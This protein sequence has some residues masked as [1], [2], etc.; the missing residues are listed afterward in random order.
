MSNFYSVLEHIQVF[1]YSYEKSTNKTQCLAVHY[2]DRMSV[3]KQV[4]RM[5][6]L[7]ETLT[8]ELVE[9]LSNLHFLFIKK[10]KLDFLTSLK[11]IIKI[12]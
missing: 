9:T 7:V 11:S 12:S 4:C 10:A 8:V 2:F 5:V 1:I 3:D 6:M